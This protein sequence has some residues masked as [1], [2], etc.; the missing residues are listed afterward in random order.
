MIFT[1]EARPEEGEA[2]VSENTSHSK[3]SK[4]KERLEKREPSKKKQK[5]NPDHPPSTSSRHEKK[6]NQGEDQGKMVYEIDESMESMVQNDKQE[7]GQTP[8]HS[9][10]QSPQ[11]D[12]NELHEEKND[13]EATS[14]FREDR[15]LLKEIQVR[16]TRSAIPDW[17]KEKLTRVVVVEEEED[18]FDLES[19]RGNSQEVMEKKKATKMSKVIR[20]ETGSRKLQ[21]A[22]PVVDKYEGE[23]LADEY[24]LETFE[25]GPLT[26]EQAME[27]ATDSFEALKDKLKEEME[28]NKK[29][30]REVSAWRSYFSR[31]NQPLRRQDPATSPLQALPLES[32]GE[33]ERVKSLVQLMSSWI[34][35]S[36]TV[37]VEFVTRMMKTVH[38]AIQVL[39]IIH[40][41]MIT[42]AAFTHTRDVIVPVLQVIR[43]TPRRILAHEKIMDEGTHNLLQW[44]ALLQMKEVLFED[45]NTRCS[46]VESI[47]HPIQDRYLR[48]CVPFLTG[49]SRSR[50]MWT[51][52]SWKIESRSSFAKKRAS[53]L[54]SNEIKCT[55]LCS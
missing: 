13:D 20:D 8:Q 44:S 27:E 29:L 12:A 32:V 10:S 18:V 36:H 5:T 6:A 42:V 45:V 26:S 51:S 4:R 25:L 1:L 43:E 21:V 31:L 47:I 24:D 40:N 3:G 37:V 2:S 46:Q 22:T 54:I 48:C 39:E 28:K 41:L 53:S 30:E 50:Q 16:E 11:V 38:R 15:P 7:K 35:K 14:P 33:A 34:D 49:G 23:I 9:S 52:K 19:L 17:L 55:L